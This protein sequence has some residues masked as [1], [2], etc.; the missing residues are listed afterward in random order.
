MMSQGSAVRGGKDRPTEVA[1]GCGEILLTL[2]AGVRAVTRTQPADTERT[3][4]CGSCG[5]STKVRTV[6]S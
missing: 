3:M 4:K 1:C 6:G 5:R 2:P